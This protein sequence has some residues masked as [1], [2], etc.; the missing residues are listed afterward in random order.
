MLSASSSIAS[1]N[2]LISLSALG[3]FGSNSPIFLSCSKTLMAKKRLCSAGT[4]KSSFRSTSAIAFSSSSPNLCTGAWAFFRARATAFSAAFSI[5]VPFKAEISTASQ[6]KAFPSFSIWIL[7]PFF[8]TK[9]IM[10][11]AITRGIPSSSN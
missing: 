9:S 10:F 6:P 1:S 3:S 4:D 7:S 5:P 11:T 8:S 2:A